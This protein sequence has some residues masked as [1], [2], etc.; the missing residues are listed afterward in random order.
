MS[1]LERKVAERNAQLA[2]A[3]ERQKHVGGEIEHQARRL[4]EAKEMAERDISIAERVQ[5]GIFPAEPPLVPGWDLAFTYRP[6]ARISGDFFDFYLKDGRLSGLALGDV[7]GHGIGAGLIAVLARSLFARRWTELGHLPLGDLLS[8]MNVD[9]TEELGGVEEYL[10]CIILR[11]E[12]GRIEYANA[13]HPD[14]LF[15]RPGAEAAMAILPRG[16]DDF[17]RAATW[18][19]RFHPRRRGSCRRRAGLVCPSLQPGPPVTS[20]S[21]ITDGL[22]EARN[23]AGESYGAE[24]LMASLSHAPAEPAAKI[25]EALARRP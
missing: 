18:Q 5:R 23:A 24:R 15:R 16:S 7:S 17:P 10:T 21:S 13:A 1:S 22:T 9:F 8:R 19:G 2:D 25:Q 14:L 4:T 3:V 12:E 20:S 6:A 11:L